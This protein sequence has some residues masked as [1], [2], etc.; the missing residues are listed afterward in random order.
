MYEISHA[1]GIPYPETD[2]YYYEKWFPTSGLTDASEYKT[3]R[4]NIRQDNLILH[5]TNSYMVL[6]GNLVKKA[7]DGAY[8]GTE[9]I[10]LIHNAIPHMFSNC[11]L[12][13]SNKVIENVNKSGACIQ[14]DV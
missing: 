11:K 6:D 7:D 5:W 12:S 10:S 3:I 14:Y 13:I 8:T 9:M 4:F 2:K 1:G